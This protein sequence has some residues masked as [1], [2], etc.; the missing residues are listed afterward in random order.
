MQT[1]CR[2][3]SCPK[4]CVRKLASPKGHGTGKEAKH[5]LTDRQKSEEEMA[6]KQT[7]KTKRN[8]D[9]L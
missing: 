7:V 6:K 2:K 1:H 3:A 8:A 9:T 5:K 4:L